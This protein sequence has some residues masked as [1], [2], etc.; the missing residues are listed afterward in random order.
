M[1]KYCEQKSFNDKMAIK[2]ILPVSLGMTNTVE[3]LTINLRQ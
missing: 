2:Y 3:M 1:Y